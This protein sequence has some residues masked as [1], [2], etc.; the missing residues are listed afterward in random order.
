MFLP[1]KRKVLLVTDVIATGRSMTRTIDD[2]AGSLANG[3]DDILGIL[4]VFRREPLNKTELPANVRGKLFCLNSDFPI[5]ICS[6]DPKECILRKEG[7]VR[8]ENE[9]LRRADETG[10]LGAPS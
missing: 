10:H 4:A 8:H 1:D 7:I 5:E 2:I 3:E 9:P 6:K